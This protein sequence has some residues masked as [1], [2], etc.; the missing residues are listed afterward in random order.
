ML[1]SNQDAVETE[2]RSKAVLGS[3]QMQLFAD[4]HAKEAALTVAKVDLC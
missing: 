1:H 3:Q 2:K 4:L